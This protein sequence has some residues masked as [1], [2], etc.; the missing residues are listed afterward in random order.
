MISAPHMLLGVKIFVLKFQNSISICGEIKPFSEVRHIQ[1]MDGSLFFQ[2]D[3]DIDN[4]SIGK[5]SIKTNIFI[6][7]YFDLL[8]YDH[9]YIHL[10]IQ[11]VRKTLTKFI[12]SQRCN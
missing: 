12:R 9:L 10:S 3:G 8:S 4:K 11:T 5:Y 7:G 6:W 2:Y 1:I